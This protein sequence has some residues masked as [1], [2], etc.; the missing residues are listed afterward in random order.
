MLYIFGIIAILLIALGILTFIVMKAMFIAMLAA[1]AAIYIGAYLIFLELIGWESVPS[2]GAAAITGTIL[3][4]ITI[5][6]LG[7]SQSSETMTWERRIGQS[8]S[9]T[10]KKLHKKWWQFWI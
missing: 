7:R 6:I 3:I 8:N 1:A 5:N 9:C 10:I 4:A 2:I